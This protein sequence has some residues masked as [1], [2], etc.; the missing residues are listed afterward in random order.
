MCMQRPSG[1]CS[2]SCVMFWKLTIDLVCRISFTK[3]CTM[4]PIEQSSALSIVKSTINSNH[5]VWS[6]KYFQCFLTKS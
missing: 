1:Q 4:I 2:H 6:S 5:L 3:A